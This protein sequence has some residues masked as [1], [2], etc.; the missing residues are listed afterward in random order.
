MISCDL[1]GKAALC[2]QKEIEGRE[3]DICEACSC[4]LEEKL[5]SKEQVKE[6]LDKLDEYVEKT[7]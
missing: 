5:S 1:C 6:I 2:L 3:L 4:L 7:V